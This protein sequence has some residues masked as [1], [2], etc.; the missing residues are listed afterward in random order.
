ML[1]TVSGYSKCSKGIAITIPKN[2][3]HLASGFPNVFLMVLADEHF[4]L[5]ETS[6][7]KRGRAGGLK[8]S[9]PRILFS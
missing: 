2:A 7:G 3:S 1:S 9:K 6:Y 5:K 8:G 4:F